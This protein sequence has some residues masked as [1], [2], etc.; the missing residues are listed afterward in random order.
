MTEIY[1]YS[2]LASRVLLGAGAI[3]RIADEVRRLGAT[4]VMLLCGARTSRTQ[5]VARIRDRL[6]TLLA[7]SFE[8]VVEHSSTRSVSEVAGRVQAGRIDLLLA[9]GG[10]SVSDTSKAVAILLAEG[11]PLS[12][13]ANRFTPPDTF[14]QQDLARPKMPILAV[15]TTASAAEVTPGAGIRDDDGHK[16]LLWD[17]KVAAR[18][19]ILDPAANLEV[20]VGIM[21]TSGMNALAHC[22][23][24]LYSKRRNPLSDA[25]AMHGLRLLAGGLRAMIEDPQRIDA[26]ARVLEG[27]YLSG[28][29]LVNTR[30]CVHHGICHC[31]GALGGLSHGV[32]NSIMLPHAMR[33]NASVAAEGL[34]RAAHALGV[35]AA[36]DGASPAERAILE[37]TRIQAVLEVPTRLRDTALER[38]MLPKIAAHAMGDRALYFNP[39]PPLSMDAVLGLLEAAW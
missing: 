12:A 39:G 19:I 23:E 14:V 16:L 25:F 9:V 21:A 13:H 33:F 32:A 35:D 26:R 17:P 28:M 24:G 29:T 5:L 3:D 34:A 27:A 31:L 4:R 6:G 10:G 30:T 20:P 15:P 36:G 18:T 7:D 38:A 1:E 8:Q 11:A 22:I 2:G 37:I